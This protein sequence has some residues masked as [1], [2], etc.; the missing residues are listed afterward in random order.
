MNVMYRVFV[1]AVALVALSCNA[2]TPRTY[3]LEQI[4]ST[5]TQEWART[6]LP[7]EG[8]APALGSD[9]EAF[10]ATLAAIRNYKA[11]HGNTDA[12]AAHLTVLEGMIHLQSG[13]PGMARLLAKD[14]EDQRQLLESGSG[15]VTRDQLF[16]DCYP[17]LVDGWEAI[18]KRSQDPQVYSEAADR[19][20][21]TLQAVDA[22]QRAAAEIDSGGAYIATSAAIFYLWASSLDLTTPDSKKVAAEKG[23]AALKPWLSTA[24]IQA[25]E[26]G[27][28]GEAGLNWGSRERFVEWYE[29]LYATAR[30]R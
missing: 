11:E 6:K 15:L 30:G 22:D 7:Q 19:L 23:V 13:H 2:L 28:A 20:V 16:A 17:A 10:K 3:Q 5:Y 26:A 12:V 21:E 25:G 8:T 27:T 9:R 18:T 24:E 29:W 1:L 14:I 4:H